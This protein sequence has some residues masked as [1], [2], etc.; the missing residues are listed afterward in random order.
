MSRWQFPLVRNRPAARK[1]SGLLWETMRQTESEEV[2]C[3]R[4]ALRVQ[5]YYLHGR[6]LQFWTFTVASNG[7]ITVSRQF[8]DSDVGKY[9][10][11]LIL[12]SGVILKA[13][14]QKWNRNT[15]AVAFCQ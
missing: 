3:C 9:L 1:V 7:S 5:R 11:G 13:I 4:Y 14:S 2:T 10:L 15:N 8:I 12:R 6:G